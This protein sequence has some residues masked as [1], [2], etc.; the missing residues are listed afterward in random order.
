[1]QTSC[2][3]LAKPHWRH[4]I[5]AREGNIAVVALLGSE[6]LT[7]SQNRLLNILSATAAVC[8]HLRYKLGR[9]QIEYM[10]P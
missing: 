1:M 10:R 9:L 7:L 8:H 6:Y 5:A 2:L 3:L 4:V